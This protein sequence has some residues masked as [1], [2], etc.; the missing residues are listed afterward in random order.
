MSAY[1]LPYNCPITTIVGITLL[2]CAGDAAVSACWWRW[3]EP[4]RRES[5]FPHRHALVSVALYGSLLCRALWA[6]LACNRVL[7]ID[8]SGKYLK[9]D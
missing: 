7:Q 5:S 9:L 6:F 8:I 1:Q 4:G 3:V 2:L